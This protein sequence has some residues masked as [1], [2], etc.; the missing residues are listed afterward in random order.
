MIGRLTCYAANCSATHSSSTAARHEVG[1]LVQPDSPA[2]SRA[3]SPH[4]LD[5]LSLNEDAGPGRHPNGSRVLIS[6]AGTLAGL[7]RFV[8][9]GCMPTA[10]GGLRAA[11]Q[12]LLR[13][14]LRL[15]CCAPAWNWSDLLAALR[16]YL[17]A[18]SRGITH[19]YVLACSRQC[20]RLVTT[21][22]Q[23]CMVTQ[24]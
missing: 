10:G 22:W 9:Q 2:A 15:L 14:L 20:A 4:R 19:D 23:R 13:R 12:V 17:H 21:Y 16:P 7:P 5:L 18:S 3:D 6:L 8:T 1:L 11:G 24:Q